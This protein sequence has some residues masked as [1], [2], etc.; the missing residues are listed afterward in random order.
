MAVHPRRVKKAGQQRH[1]VGSIRD[2]LGKFL[3]TLARH[4]ARPLAEATDVFL[5]HSARTV[6]RQPHERTAPA[7]TNGPGSAPAAGLDQVG[8]EVL[9]APSGS[10]DECVRRLSRLRRG[11]G[12]NSGGPTSIHVFRSPEATASGPLLP[13]RTGA[14][15][16]PAP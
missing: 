9:F 10:F 5:F 7:T 16:V 11:V 3:A 2:L 1:E 4:H 13:P 6:A 15:V 8:Q 14:G 12:T